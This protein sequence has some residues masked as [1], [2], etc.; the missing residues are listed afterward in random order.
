MLGMKG[1]MWR[2]KSWVYLPYGG[3]TLYYV[4]PRHPCLAG[5]AQF[6]G[7]SQVPQLVGVQPGS[8]GSSCRPAGEDELEAR[9]VLKLRSRDQ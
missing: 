2:P 1:A 3:V 7:V 6:V 5:W 8:W 9:E 4:L